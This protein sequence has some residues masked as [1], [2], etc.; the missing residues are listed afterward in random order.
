MMQQPRFSQPSPS[1]VRI[2]T[3][4]R[5]API[6]SGL[7]PD[8]TLSQFWE[9]VRTHQLAGNRPRYHEAIG[10]SVRVWAVLTGDPPLCSIDQDVCAAFACELKARCWRGKPIS[11][12]SRHRHVRHVQRLLDLAA[13]RDRYNRDGV[14]DAG[15]YGSDAFGRPRSAPWIDKPRLGRP[16][17]KP[18]YSLADLEAILKACSVATIPCLPGVPPPEWW[19]S[20]FVWGWNVGTRIDTTLALE[21]SML[22]TVDGVRWLHIPAAILKTGD[23]AGEEEFILHVNEPA[24]AAAL[25]IRIPGES[26][27]FV[28]PYT[29]NYWHAYRR[30]TIMA[31][32]GL[33]RESY[34]G[35]GYHPCRRSLG[36]RLAKKAGSGVA[37]KQ[38][39]HTVESTTDNHYVDLSVVLAPLDSLE[40]PRID[41]Q[42]KLFE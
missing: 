12:L 9:H 37:R 20:I 26:R 29:R 40:Q 11:K 14:T 34:L 36:T 2:Y 16:R 27:L 3:G 30:Q 33:P 22:R 8:M 42:P 17:A 15:L 7:S 21:W 35:K 19:R 18:G 6:H 41:R 24:Y 39:G 13:P 10:D 25:A 5:D 4:E 31:A 28:W 38:L 23:S 32:T 1:F